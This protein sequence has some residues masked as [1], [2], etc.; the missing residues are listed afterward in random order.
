MAIPGP[1]RPNI[2]ASPKAVVIP[3]ERFPHGVIVP[4]GITTPTPV[5]ATIAQIKELE[6]EVVATA[7]VCR[8]AGFDGVELAAHMSYLLATFLSPRSNW[9][10]DEYGGS[11]ENRGRILANITAGI[12]KAQGPDFVIGLRLPAN[13]YAPD[14]QGAAGFAAVAKTV[15]AAGLD[16][17]ALSTGS[18]ETMD[19]SVPMVDGELVDSGDARIFKE[20]L[21]VPILIQGIHEP[22]RAAKA[23]AEGNGDLIMLARPSLADAEYARKVIEGRPETIVKCIR[24]HT[25]MR[26][27]LM[28]AP[29][30]CDVNPQMG[31]ESRKGK[32]PPLKRLIQAP[33]EKVGLA[34]SS[35]RP[36]MQLAMKLKKH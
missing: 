17:V 35:S 27:M 31:R 26:R 5:E 23:I 34:V 22:N 33:M 36:V 4:G 12:R 1:G 16:Y 13:D 3:E 8:R 2:A 20:T 14:S 21:S 11:P 10:T 19:A 29:I 30:R 7:D 24:T 18:Y 6:A 32:P 9:R 15:E 25:C 28:N